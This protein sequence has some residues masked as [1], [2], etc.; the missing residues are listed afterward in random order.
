M[1]DDCFHLEK[2]IV[3]DINQI[4]MN[5]KVELNYFFF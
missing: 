2:E 5:E 3:Q 1:I 4:V